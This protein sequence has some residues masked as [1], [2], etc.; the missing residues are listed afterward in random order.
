[1]TQVRTLRSTKDKVQASAE[2]LAFIT[3][4]DKVKVL[5]APAGSGK[6]FTIVESINLLAKKG[7]STSL[8]LFDRANANEAKKRV[9]NKAETKTF[10][11][12]AYS[13]HSGQSKNENFRNRIIASYNPIDIVA[14]IPWPKYGIS[15]KDRLAVVGTM[16]KV[17]ANH[18]TSADA[19]FNH[20]HLGGLGDVPITSDS[21]LAMA[22][23]FYQRCMQDS[24][25]PITFDVMLKSYQLTK[26]YLDVDNVYIDEAQ[27]TNPVSLDIAVAQ[28]I[29]SHENKRRKLTKLALVGDKD[30]SIY[31]FR[32]AVNALEGIDV[33]TRYTL[34]ESRRFGKKIGMLAQASINSFKPNAQIV[35]RGV[36]TTPEKLFS[37]N[38]NAATSTSQNIKRELG[39]SRILDDAR[40]GK[41]TMVLCRSL[42][43]IAEAC[44]EISKLNK[45]MNPHNREPSLPYRLAGGV[46]RYNFDKF[47]AASD[48]FIGETPRDSFLKMFNGWGE[49]EDF[50]EATQSNDLQSI[51]TFVNRYKKS[52]GLVIKAIKAQNYDAIVRRKQKD[53]PNAKIDLPYV[54]VSSGHR[55][56]GLEADSV[57]VWDDF[58]AFNELEET[59]YSSLLGDD[60]YAETEQEINL[61]YVAITRAKSKL[62]IPTKWSIMLEGLL[63]GSIQEL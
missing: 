24:S 47:I 36:N 38:S 9:G 55:A 19:N 45:Q 32:N 25:M 43:G 22:K 1:M 4:T 18:C 5:Q 50:V 15:Q 57:M 53:K 31:R 46:K 42:L 60:T 39:V 61:S 17:L 49:F 7:E 56:K 29:R 63:T 51:V 58:K 27:D 62:I 20:R 52:A 21:L 28:I 8:F 54:T 33:A 41:S 44:S 59:L 14:M 6:T 10:H 35:I 13:Y 3:S 12:L 26:P 40:A 34:T 48:L 30:Q 16:L 11:S 2:Q 23:Q 37:Y